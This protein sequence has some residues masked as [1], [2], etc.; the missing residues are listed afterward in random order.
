MLQSILTAEVFIDIFQIGVSSGWDLTLANKLPCL[1][2]SGNIGSKN[3]STHLA[4]LGHLKQM[5]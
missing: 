1:F 4:G 2:L 3:L 5:S